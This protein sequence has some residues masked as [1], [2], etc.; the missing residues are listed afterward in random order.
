MG[1]SFYRVS[2]DGSSEDYFF[3]NHE[4][5]ATF[6]LESYFDDFEPESEDDVIAM[7][8]EVADF[9]GIECYGWID[10]LYFEQ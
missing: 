3:H 2:F 9:N 5:A 6:L 8:N 7:N 10:E 1:E 4:D